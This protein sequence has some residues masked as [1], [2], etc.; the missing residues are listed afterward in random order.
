MHLVEIGETALG[1]GTEKVQGRRRLVIDLY[2][3]FWVWHPFFFRE[4][5]AVDHIT[6][7]RIESDAVNGLRIR[8][9]RLGE[10]AR[11]AACFYHWKGGAEGQHDGHLQQDFEGIADIIGMEFGEAFGAIATL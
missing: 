8:R 11:Q 10:L 7:V 6:P 1:E 2:Q 5:H 9:A 3:A 4:L